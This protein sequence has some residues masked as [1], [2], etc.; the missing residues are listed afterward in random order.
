MNL[1]KSKRLPE[2]FQLLVQFVD[3]FFALQLKPGHLK[4]FKLYLTKQINKSS[5]NFDILQNQANQEGLFYL[6]NKSIKKKVAL[7]LFL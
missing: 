1:L 3:K 7:I 5:N 4:Y 6:I 2:D